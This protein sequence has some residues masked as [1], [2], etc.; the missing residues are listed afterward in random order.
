MK[1]IFLIFKQTY[2]EFYK[3]RDECK[4][5]IEDIDGDV[6]LYMS[7][8]KAAYDLI[9]NLSDVYLYCPVEIRTDFLQKTLDFFDNGRA[10]KLYSRER[11]GYKTSDWGYGFAERIRDLRKD[12]ERSRTRM[13]EEYKK[14]NWDICKSIYNDAKQIIKDFDYK[15]M[16][17][18]ITWHAIEESSK[19]NIEE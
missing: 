12:L 11:P 8:E 7:K 15:Y 4:K 5:L 9:K 14:G 16:T 18:S 1:N 10:I 2:K 6:I 3:E 19:Q 13:K 17:D